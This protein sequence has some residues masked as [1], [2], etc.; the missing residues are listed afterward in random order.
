MAL[1]LSLEATKRAY[2]RVWA[3]VDLAAIRH[4]I[5]ALR[6]HIAPAKL[7][8]V[9]KANAYGLGAIPVAK[10]AL[11]AGAS[12]L[13]VATVEEGQELRQAG[14][15]AQ[16]LVLGYTPPELALEAVQAGLTL[17]INSPE[18]IKALA[19][20]IKSKPALMS[21]ETLPVH[22]KLET[23]LHRFGLEAEE[24]LQ[25]ARLISSTQGLH[26][27]G[28]YSHFATGDEIDLS[29]V[30]EQQRRFEDGRKLLEQQGFQFDQLHFSNSASGIS[31]KEA[32]YDL[33]RT[34]L[35]IY[36]YYPSTIVE[37]RARD[38]C[39]NLRPALTLKSVIARLSTLEKGESVGY[40]RTYIAQNNRRLALVPV[41]Y[42]DGY[43]RAMS[44]QAEVLVKGQKVEVV[45]RVSMDQIVL[46]ITGLE[47]SLSEGDEVV[48][49][50]SSSGN[51]IPLE[52]VARI[53]GT[54]T[55]EIL[56]GLGRRVKRVYTDS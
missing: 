17:T 52:E 56:T 16:I 55:Y 9:V 36:G 28:L 21:G 25:I 43:C 42:A 27:Q 47:S 6:K 7:M 32:R 18:L 22:L 29:F 3:E 19:V 46:D 40:N 13:A 23:G 51:N 39:L 12:S 54:I 53:C 14:I 30:Y 26:L 35:A 41:G 8:A 45:G 11:E 33:V 38:A 20:A 1:S 4:N 31:L 44:N 37:T 49:I 24:A 10:V 34:G 5:V 50:G 48:L 2:S 15:T